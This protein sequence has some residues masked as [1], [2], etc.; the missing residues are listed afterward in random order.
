VFTIE[1]PIPRDVLFH[2]IFPDME[3]NEMFHLGIDNTAYGLGAVNFRITLPQFRECL[4]WMD[5]YDAE[6][7]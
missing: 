5:Q 4:Q 2:V 6:G 7:K 1:A 3:N